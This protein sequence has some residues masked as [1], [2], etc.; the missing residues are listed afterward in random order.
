MNLYTLLNHLEIDK[1]DYH[2]KILEA[3]HSKAKELG[4]EADIDPNLVHDVDAL[5]EW[6]MV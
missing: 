1:N 6:R 4:L 5:Y 3:E 2:D